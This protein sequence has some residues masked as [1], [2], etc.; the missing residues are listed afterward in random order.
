M[1]E[2]KHN[3][4]PVPKP[5]TDPVE[6]RISWWLENT[7]GNAFTKVWNTICNAFMDAVTWSLDNWRIILQPGVH[8]GVSRVI[9][10][11]KTRK[12]VS[13]SL[14]Q[15]IDA[16]FAGNTML[17]DITA[18][19]LVILGITGVLTGVTSVISD[20]SRFAAERDFRTARL[21]PG[22]LFT[23]MRKNQ[24]SWETT[25]SY[26]LDAGW[27]DD[28]IKAMPRILENPIPLSDIVSAYYRKIFDETKLGDILSEQGYNTIHIGYIKELI[29]QIPPVQD[30]IRMAVRDTWNEKAV[31]QYGYDE[32]YPSEV[33]EWTAKQGIGADWAKRYW[34][35]HWELPSPNMLYE[36]MHRGVIT[37]DEARTALRIADYP[38][39][40]RDKLMKIS[41]RV[42]TRVDTRRM[43]ARGVLSAEDV[44]NEYKA[45]G[46]DNTRA[47][48]MRD[49]TIAEYQSKEKELSKS[50]ILNAYK[51]SII[52]YDDAKKYLIDLKYSALDAWIILARVTLEKTTAYDK[53]LVENVRLLYVS[54]RISETEV[55]AR[56]GEIAPPAGF[57]QDKLRLWR[58]QRAR[59]TTALTITEIKEAF[60][61]GLLNN[62]NVLDKLPRLGYSAE[63]ASLLLNT[64]VRQRVYSQQ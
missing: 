46:Y 49:W 8:A 44:Y 11:Y 33:G 51:D 64:W 60:L 48:Q 58:L 25:R 57:V 29:K 62:D 53:E 59:Q 40:W 16:I 27:P 30:L 32:D 52:S 6:R 34:R 63:D 9:T 56:L 12:N 23:A 39:F 42:F 14:T 54:N 22:D 5:G 18:L 47:A 20:V 4:V 31:A 10:G 38:K 50:D 37:E 17:C 1:P 2:P 43:Y 19:I 41:Y 35:A 28:I 55:Y 21:S 13:P 26:L 3:L 61:A 45:Q 7:F 15:E 36:M 24:L